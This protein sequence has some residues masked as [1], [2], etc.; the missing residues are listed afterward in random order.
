M[1]PTD[2]L[3]DILDAAEERGW[4]V[5]FVDVRAGVVAL[6]EPV[7]NGLVVRISGRA[8]TPEFILSLPEARQPAP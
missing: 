5:A 7:A 4:A 6:E 8:I 2:Y 1:T 3:R